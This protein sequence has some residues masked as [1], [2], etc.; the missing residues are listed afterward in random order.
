MSVTLVPIDVG[1]PEDPHGRQKRLR[2]RFDESVAALPEDADAIGLCRY[3]EYLERRIVTLEKTLRVTLVAN[4]S[5]A[6][7]RA[8]IIHTLFGAV[9]DQRDGNLLNPREARI[10]R[11]R[12]RV[13]PRQRGG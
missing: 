2:L 12:Q 4:P 8:R 3:A 1:A 11:H 7:Q 9:G 13:A 10:V 5:D 6:V